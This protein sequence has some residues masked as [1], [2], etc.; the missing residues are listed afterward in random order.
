MKQLKK[1]LALVLALVMSLSLMTVGTHAIGVGGSDKL[2]VS[3]GTSKIINSTSNYKEISVEE[4][5]SLTIGKNGSFD[6]EKLTVADGGYLTNYGTLQTDELTIGEAYVTNGKGATLTVDTAATIGNATVEGTGTFTLGETATIDATGMSDENK[7]A[8]KDMADATDGA[9]IDGEEVEPEPVTY[10][11]TASYTA[12][13]VVA[14]VKTIV[15]ETETD[16]TNDLKKTGTTTVTIATD[17]NEATTKLAENSGVSFTVT[18]PATYTL[19]TFTVTMGGEDVTA[20]LESEATSETVT[21]YTLS[22][23]TGDVVVTTE[24]EKK[25]GVNLIIYDSVMTEGN[26]VAAAKV[27]SGSDLAG[28]AGVDADSLPYKT[29]TVTP[30]AQVVIAS[31]A[32][33]TLTNDATYEIA[34]GVFAK[35]TKA[36]GLLTIAEF[37]DEDVTIKV[38]PSTAVVPIHYDPSLTIEAV[39]EADVVEEDTTN[40]I[41]WIKAAGT[42]FEVTGSDTIIVTSGTNGATD[43]NGSAIVTATASNGDTGSLTAESWI[44][45][46]VVVTLDTS[47][48]D[49]SLTKLSGET[50]TITGTIASD[51]GVVPGTKL[52]VAA[53]SD[54]TQG[55]GVLAIAT[56]DTTTGNGKSIV[57]TWEVPTVNTTLYGAVKVT[58][59]TGITAVLQG[60]TVNSG[61]YVKIVDTEVNQT[62]PTAAKLSFTVAKDAGTSVM[63]V[64]G[65]AY[66]HGT[67]VKT[68]LAAS[69]GDLLLAPG[70]KITGNSD[71]DITYGSPAIT[72]TTQLSTDTA[73]YVRP[74]TE[75]TIVGEGNDKAVTAKDDAATPNVIELTEVPTNGSAPNQY[76]VTT[77]VVNIV[78]SEAA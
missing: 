60:K 37:P 25:A 35:C 74:N 72:V 23:I 78:L 66:K 69:D 41:V 57:G 54:G 59:E 14:D 68:T 34:D 10:T 36:S 45:P 53:K 56:S 2:T 31:Q 32:F 28:V 5:A 16:V 26:E 52:T 39:T 63:V 18:T 43:I 48:A 30:G 20:D 77:G 76:T 19:K 70:I 44:K 42:K 64:K 38:A 13:A 75:I 47:A 21:T 49:A 6:G 8:L 61:D 7:T 9:K 65:A 24:A 17:P 33:Y 3:S 67:A 51:Q 12:G 40:H 22:N 62:T 15:G 4:N 11:F 58:M 71:A 55:T 73:V 27:S 1:L 46:A 50:Y 29:Y